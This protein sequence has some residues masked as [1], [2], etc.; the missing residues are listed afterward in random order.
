MPSPDFDVFV[1][2]R[3]PEGVEVARALTDGLRSLGF[4][5]YFEA[6]GKGAGVDARRQAMEDAHDF[7]LVVTPGTFAGVASP[8]DPVRQELAEAL[9]LKRVV[10]PVCLPGGRVPD[11]DGLPDEISAVST[12]PITVFDPARVRTSVAL[13]SHSLSSDATLEDRRLERRALFVAWFVGLVFAGVVAYFVVP[14]VF[15]F[16][17]TPPPKPAVAPF[18]VSWAAVARPEGTGPIVDVTDTGTVSA[19][20]RLKIW[21]SPSADG[22][23]YVF[24]RNARGEVSVLFPTQ[25]LRGVASV[26]AG[27]VYEAPAADTWFEPG[28]TAQAIVIVAGYDALE[29]FEELAE[30]QDNTARASE[31]R[32]LLDDTV[33]GLIDG[34]HGATPRTPR[35]RTGH[36]VDRQLRPPPAAAEVRRTLADGTVIDKPM[37]PQRGIISAAV[38]VRLSV[39]AAGR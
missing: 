38:E 25:A 21:F 32:E 35:T 24:A 30:D 31:R 16:L 2:C 28:D 4:H 14:P 11:A 22:F 5:V 19:R 29:N 34:R 26:K 33:A 23:A 7:I 18:V 8:D 12:Q 3:E 1:S 37:T 13:V 9:R 20:D 15:R 10:V 6:R 17:F 36:P 27:Q 39:R